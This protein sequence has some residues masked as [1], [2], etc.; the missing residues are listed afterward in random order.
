MAG[1]CCPG[2]DGELESCCPG[3]AQQHL[4]EPCI[5][6]LEMEMATDPVL[7]RLFPVYV[8][9]GGGLYQPGLYTKG[10]VMSHQF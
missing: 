5:G 3:Y 2:L 10:F 6:H 8:N 7:F 9:I 1:S 4:F